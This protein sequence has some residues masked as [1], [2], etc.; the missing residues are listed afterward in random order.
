MEFDEFCSH[1]GI[2][3]PTGK[4]RTCICGTTLLSP[5]EDLKTRV[6]VRPSVFHKDEGKAKED[7]DELRDH[8]VRPH[9][10]EIES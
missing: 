8:I 3:N 7:I 2:K 1:C 9:P 4:M 6:Q 10:L 5:V